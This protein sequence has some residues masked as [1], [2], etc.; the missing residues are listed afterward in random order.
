M[1]PSD[2][3]IPKF[4]LHHD[5]W[6]R[7]VLTDADGHAHVGV[8][9]IRS[10]PLSEPSRG[11]S[12][13]NSSGRELAWVEDPTQLQAQA[14][15]CLEDDL[16]RREFVPTILRIVSVSGG[17]EPSEWDVE[18]DRGRTRFRLKSED[19]VRRLPA[20]RAMITD[21]NGVRYLIPNVRGFNSDAARILERYL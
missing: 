16:A 7:L 8:E 14:R 17:S 11:I 10:F 5:E 18:T 13:C 3:A 20:D 1:T 21:A 15:Q 4:V 12:V 9:C 19:D 6:G 2:S